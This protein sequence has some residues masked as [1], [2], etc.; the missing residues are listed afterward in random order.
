MFIGTASIL[1]AIAALLAVVGLVWLAG[2]LARFGGLARRP[3]RGG[4]LHVQDVLVLDA[5]RR[6]HLIRCDDRRL[7]LLTG[8][9]QDVVVGWI[10][11][12]D[13]PPQ[14]QST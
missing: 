11:R 13:Q 6:L 2:R 3:V 8:G 5:R 9:S 1:S 14:D 7:L 4:L 10:G 12:R